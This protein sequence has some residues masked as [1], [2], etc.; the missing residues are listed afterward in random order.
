MTE[1]KSTEPTTRIQRGIRIAATRAAEI[2]RTG[3]D[4]YRV[5]GSGDATYTVRLAAGYCSCP[6]RAPLCKHRVAAQIIDSRD[7]CRRAKTA[8]PKKTRHADGLKGIL[9][10]PDRLAA[11][12]DRLAV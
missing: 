7:A 4:T 8:R 12:A 9:T 6:D 3:P 10:D 1:R 5:P 11:V 2:V